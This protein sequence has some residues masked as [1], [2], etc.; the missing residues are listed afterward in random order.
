MSTTL[1][2]KWPVPICSVFLLL[3]QSPLPSCVS[4]ILCKHAGEGRYRWFYFLWEKQKLNTWQSNFKIFP[5]HH[6]KN[7]LLEFQ[8]KL[9]HFFRES[10]LKIFFCMLL[11]GSMK[12][13]GGSAVL[14]WKQNLN[15]LWTRIS[16]LC[17]PRPSCDTRAVTRGRSV[18]AY[19]DLKSEICSISWNR[20]YHLT[21]TGVSLSIDS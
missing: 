2:H 1:Y 14:L 12:S 4:S 16:C 9:H 20:G 3:R 19:S 17:W 6:L 10:L 8:G 18:T 11:Y 13:N 7:H 5:V 21:Q 15:K